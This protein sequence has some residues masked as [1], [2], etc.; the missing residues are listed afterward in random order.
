MLT[1]IAA[2]TV[3]AN[4]VLVEVFSRRGLSPLSPSREQGRIHVISNGGEP[5][6]VVIGPPGAAMPVLNSWA[7]WNRSSRIRWGVVRTAAAA[8]TLSWLP[9]VSSEFAE[10]D[11]SYWRAQLPFFP[12][13]WS[14][15]I[16]IG[17]PSYTR[18]AI[19]FLIDRGSRV[20]C[21][22]KIPLAPDSSQAILNEADM[23]DRLSRFDY[24]PRVLFWDR[25]RGIAAQSWLEGKPVG[26]GFSN[27]HLD[28]LNSLACP[29]G[30]V[31]ICDY[32]PSLEEGLGKLDLP[33]DR[34]VLARSL[35]MLDCDAP[36]PAFVEH[37]DFA[38]WNLKWIGIGVLGLL[39]WEWA[40]PVGLPWQDACRH[41]YL[42]DAHFRGSGQVWETLKANKILL[43]Y[44]RRSEIPDRLLAPLTMRY[45]LRELIMEWEG[46]NQRLAHYAYRQIV[47]L[48]EAAVRAGA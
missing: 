26:R 45:L 14:A 18:K 3:K 19:L 17:S 8:N 41:F 13:H 20:V 1:A 36:L 34:S 33:F 35:E 15:V 47:A 46:G 11:L 23:L 16:H 7:P 6:W 24:L 30:L 38:P 43:E 27:A 25:G 29:N 9:G 10:L 44:R 39:D 2:E 31:R 42:D 4:D 32:R 21:A 22:A 5:R 48:S 40:E 37:R 12:E 28:L